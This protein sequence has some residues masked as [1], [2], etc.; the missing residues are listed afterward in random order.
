M[1]SFTA[2]CSIMSNSN[3]RVKRTSSLRVSQ[4]NPTKVN[5]P[6]IGTAIQTPSGDIRVE[7][8]DGSVLTVS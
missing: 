1:P 5:V 8:K 6:G 7:F 3:S 2:T 4:Q